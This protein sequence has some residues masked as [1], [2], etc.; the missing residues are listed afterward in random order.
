LKH[1]KQDRSAF[2]PAK[3]QRARKPARD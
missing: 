1:L 2:S 3:S